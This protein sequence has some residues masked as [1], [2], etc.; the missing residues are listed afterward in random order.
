MKVFGFL[1]SFV[2]TIALVFALSWRIG[3]LPPLGHFLDPFHGFW[4]NAEENGHAI[5]TDLALEP[6]SQPV[7]VQYDSLLIPHIFAQN[8]DDLYRA[9]GYVQ[10]RH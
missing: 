6:L 1:L 4:Q 2:A 8:D 3:P 10:A 7:T 9:Q 5:A